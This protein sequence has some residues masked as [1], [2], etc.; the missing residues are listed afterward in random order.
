MFTQF[1]SLLGVGPI[2]IAYT[3]GVTELKNFYRAVQSLNANGGGDGPEYA[4]HA[5]LEGLLAQDDEGFS[6]VNSGSQ[7]IVITDAISKQPDLKSNVTFEA[8][9]LGVCIHFFV[10]GR[11]GLSDGI[12]QD[13]ANKT[14]GTLVYPYDSWEIAAFTQS[15][16]SRPCR[17]IVEERRKK[18]QASDI[19]G[20][21]QSFI[22]TEFSIL[23]KLT[24]NAL[25]GKK[26]TLTM[27][28][29]TTK[30]IRVG[31]GNLALFSETNPLQGQWKACVTTGTV[32]VVATNTITLDITV[33]YIN[34][35]NESTSLPPPSCK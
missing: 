30:S 14:S 15:Y 31:S 26:V 7:M 23:L 32:R 27:P 24:I 6:V 29:N 8:N 20:Q 4:L 28:T 13:I 22:V 1:L 34:S 5:M 11:Y 35:K 19:P 10:S 33:I 18:R 17:H 16:R 9:Y 2:T 21:C 25:I 3:E 12:Y